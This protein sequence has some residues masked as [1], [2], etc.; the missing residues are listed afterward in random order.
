MNSVALHLVPRAIPV[1]MWVDVS[2][3]SPARAAPASGAPR[4]FRALYEAEFS[5]VWN[6][7][8]RLGA[9]PAHIEDLAHDTFVTAWR[10]MGDYDPSR[11]IRPWLFGIAF[12]V[13]S[14]FRKRAFQQREVP[15]ENLDK[16]DAEDDRASPVDHVAAREAREL[17]M[18]ALE[19]MPVERRA[20]FVM[21]ELDGHAAPEI[22]DAMSIPLNTAYSRLRLARQ[23]FAAAIKRIQASE[24]GAR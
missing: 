6:S 14:D 7:L 13:A 19:S 11:P 22:A 2:P 17:V 23:D 12:R 16:V 20:V 15:D 18:R 8:R 4:D 5:Y 1:Y 21:H 3:S 9:P 24:R 10:R